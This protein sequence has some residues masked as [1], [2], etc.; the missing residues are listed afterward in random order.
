MRVGECAEEMLK[1]TKKL[2]PGQPTVFQNLS[3][4]VEKD[5]KIA[6]ERVIRYFSGV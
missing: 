5:K 2:H 1:K 3:L 4:L 6:P